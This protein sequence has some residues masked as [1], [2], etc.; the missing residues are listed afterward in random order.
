MLSDL[1]VCSYTSKCVANRLKKIY[2]QSNRLFINTVQIFGLILTHTGTA[3][4]R[5]YNLRESVI[6]VKVITN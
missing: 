2:I 3:R 4:L 1:D 6:D 5:N